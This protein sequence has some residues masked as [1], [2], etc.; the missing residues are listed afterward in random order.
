MPVQK[1]LCYINTKKK[2]LL[3]ALFNTSTNLTSSLKNESLSGLYR[4]GLVGCSCFRDASMYINKIAK[5]F[6]PY[7]MD[8]QYWQDYIAWF[9]CLWVYSE[10]MFF[11]LR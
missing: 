7:G 9:F 1:E 6:Y 8:M 3:T 11:Y 5:I 4:F 2:K 10:Q